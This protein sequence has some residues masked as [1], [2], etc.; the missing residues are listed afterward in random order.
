M[1]KD[2]Q[3]ILNTLK[4]DV[5]TSFKH[6]NDFTDRVADVRLFIF[7]LSHGLVWVCEINRIHHWCLVGTGKSNQRWT[8]GLGFFLEWSIIFSH[9][10][11][12]HLA[13]YCII[14]VGDV[15]EFD[16][17]SQWR[18]RCTQINLKHGLY[19]YSTQAR[20]RANHHE[21]I[22]YWFEGD[23]WGFIIFFSNRDVLRVSPNSDTMSLRLFGGIGSIRLESRKNSLRLAK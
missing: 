2:S 6:F 1:N 5:V 15:T 18:A 17:Y 19:P 8:W 14:F 11:I 4:S 23:S 3:K 21:L 9:I 12:L 7:Y 22:F 10:P 13:T 16:V 20:N